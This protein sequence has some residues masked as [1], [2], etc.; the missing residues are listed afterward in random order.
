MRHLIITGDGKPYVPFA[1]S[2]IKA[3]R[4]TG[5]KYA[6]QNYEVNDV[7]IH[8]RID[9]DNEYIRIDGSVFAYQ[10]FSTGPTL[11]FRVASGTDSTSFAYYSG[12]AIGVKEV[13]G[14]TPSTKAS[15]AG[16]SLAINFSGDFSQKFPI[17]NIWQVQGITEHCYHP[18]GS[19]GNLLDSK[20]INSWSSGTQIEGLM[21]KGNQQ[22]NGLRKLSV[23]VTYD[24]PPAIKGKWVV[25]DTDWYKKAAIRTVKHPDYGSRTFILMTDVSGNLYVYPSESEI[26]DDPKAAR[27]TFAN[28]AIKTN[29][30]KYGVKKLAIPFPSWARTTA[31]VAREKWATGI[32]LGDLVRDI[33]QYRWAFN[34]A[35]TLMAAVVF[36][37]LPAFVNEV[38]ATGTFSSDAGTP[39]PIQE[40]LP[41]MLEIGIN[42]QLSGTQLGDFT[43]ALT[44]S[45]EMRPTITGKYI[46]GCDYA[47][48]VEGYA[49]LDDL[50]LMTGS[51]YHASG[52]RSAE[53]R[54]YNLNN[55][56]CF[57]DIENYSSAT[58][59][60]SF[61][62]R[63]TSRSYL[64]AGPD[65]AFIP[66]DEPTCK[67]AN[68]IFLAYD[69]RRLAFVV[70]QKYTE[71]DVTHLTATNSQVDMDARATAMRVLT[72]MD[73]AL[74]QT[75]ALEPSGSSVD[76]ALAAYFVDD[77]RTGL[78]KMPIAENGGVSQRLTTTLF[79]GYASL[80]LSG[81][82][83][84]YAANT[85]VDIGTG[86]TVYAGAI[87]YS[88]YI[89]LSLRC[90]GANA[91]AL[92][93]NG[94]WS[95]NTK[96][97]TY[98]A[99]PMDFGSSNKYLIADT[100]D[101]SKMRSTR[102][103]MVKIKTP[104]GV[105]S[106]T[107]LEM[108]NEATNNNYTLADFLPR[109]E[110]RTY[111]SGSVVRKFLVD[112]SSDRAFELEQTS[113][114]IPNFGLVRPHDFDFQTQPTVLWDTVDGIVSGLTTDL[115]PV[116]GGSQ[117]FI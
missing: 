112:A 89:A 35:G 27:A 96:P 20:L 107:H 101:V 77:S 39:I 21:S 86:P 94:S 80:G 103:D 4:S 38:G 26:L 54:W 43:A 110:K 105:V 74:V 25:P 83:S 93:P 53:L 75:I 28:Q 98:F 104:N 13:K 47:W 100:F 61:L 92:H 17:K 57:I 88:L 55:N 58:V 42:I 90:R 102:V 8:V 64:S 30:G 45:S 117:L 72:Y 63:H 36:E 91:F 68:A 70:R 56:K 10:F 23:D 109:W 6:S 82:N 40:T 62:T 73:N 97:V 113:G 52:D 7:K 59:L 76:A 3:L 22:L 18:V 2:R 78:F 111:L 33:P 48:P 49:A 1:K 37:D 99:G 114:G 32:T 79:N 15:V 65:Y 41:G 87:V 16:N 81:S 29:I 19:S 66:F 67:D 115:T 34:S 12:Y 24:L 69:L 44:V 14:K 46:V 31:D 85:S 60:R 84:P 11:K 106:T 9:P 108:L 51:V 71:F 95:V 50:I 116:L 5:L